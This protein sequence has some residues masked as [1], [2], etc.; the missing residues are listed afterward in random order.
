MERELIRV[1]NAVK[2]KTGIKIQA[3][4]ENGVYYASTIGEFIAIGQDW[5]SSAKEIGEV[6]GLTYF[7]FNFEYG[8]YDS[9][10]TIE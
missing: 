1:L 7:K 6:D 5:F 8:V 10:Y 9:M 4:S 3:V 2:D